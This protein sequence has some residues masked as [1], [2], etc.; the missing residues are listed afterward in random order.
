M[1]AKGVEYGAGTVAG[2]FTNGGVSA[3]VY[4]T[5]E[6]VM[7]EDEAIHKRPEEIEK[8]IAYARERLV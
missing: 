2:V 5:D 6:D 1:F 8:A 4:P 7:C 3:Y